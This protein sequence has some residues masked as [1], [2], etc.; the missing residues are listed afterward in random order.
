M[1]QNERIDFKLYNID[2][3][4]WNTNGHNIMQVL[5]INSHPR[6]YM[7]SEILHCLYEF[8]T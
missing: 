8:I 1:F 7:K 4:Q 6:T 3:F 2:N 5:T